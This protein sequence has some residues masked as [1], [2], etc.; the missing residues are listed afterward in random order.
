MGRVQ[1]VGNLDSQ[2][3]QFVNLEGLGR[4]AMLERLPFQ[5]LHGDEGLA[6]ELI[7]VVNRADVRMVEG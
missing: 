4:N 3:D 6:S 2:M 1:R 5:Q 7:S